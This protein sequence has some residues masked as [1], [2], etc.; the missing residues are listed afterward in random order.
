MYEL[1]FPHRLYA[2]LAQERQLHISDLVRIPPIGLRRLPNVAARSVYITEQILSVL[3]FHLGMRETDI[4]IALGQQSRLRDVAQILRNF[5]A[6]KLSEGDAVSEIDSLYR[7]G[8]HE[9]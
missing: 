9:Q 4:D 3:G 6:N 1:P 5:A 7:D 2:Q 8:A